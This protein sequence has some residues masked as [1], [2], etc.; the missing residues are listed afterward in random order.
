[1]GSVS[2]DDASTLQATGCHAVCYNKKHAAKAWMG[3]KCAWK[4]CYSC[5]ECELKTNL[6]AQGARSVAEEKAAETLGSKQLEKPPA[7]TEATYKAA[8]PHSAAKKTTSVTKKSKHVTKKNKA[9]AESSK[10]SKKKAA[11]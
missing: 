3:D 4:H 7:T 10:H 1:M 2:H 9:M 11:F 5:P 8:V 6:R